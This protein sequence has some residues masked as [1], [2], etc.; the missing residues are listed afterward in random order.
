MTAEP[1]QVFFDATALIKVGAPPGNETF[2]RLADLVGYGFITVV[3][4]DLNKSE[5]TRHHAD[6]AFERLRQLSSRRFRR[7]A[8]RYFNIVVPDM[9]ETELRKQIK[10]HIADGVAEM[11]DRLNAKTVDIN[12]VS[13]SQIFDD[14]D[15][16]AGFFVAQNKKYQFPD[17]FIFQ[18][19]KQVATAATPLL[20]VSDDPDYCKPVENEDH[21]DLIISID[22]LFGRLGLLVNEPDPDLEPFMYNDLMG[23]GDFLNYVELES[24][25]FQEYKLSTICHTINFD[26]ITAFQQLVE[27]ALILVSAKVSVELDVQREYHD[28][29]AVETERG[30]ADVSFYASIATDQDGDPSGITEL[31]IY[32]CSLH[33]SNG[34]MRW[35]L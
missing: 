17:A 5:I 3:T 16:S 9:S 8:S 29:A 15:Q 11:F 21:F 32:D 27:S 19:L 4:T 12:T 2:R 18:T 28:G 23:N 34:S 24:E 1:L 7:L 30:L 20:I 33:W 13:P 25:D 22:D 10:Q 14:F 35:V 31:R 6:L 26:N